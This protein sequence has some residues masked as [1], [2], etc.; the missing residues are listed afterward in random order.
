MY[1]TNVLEG[2]V[3]KKKGCKEDKL[4]YCIFINIHVRLLLQW[5]WFS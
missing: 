5:Q 2:E 4:L 1:M 3:L